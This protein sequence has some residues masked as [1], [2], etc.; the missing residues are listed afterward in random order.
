MSIYDYPYGGHHKIATRRFKRLEHVYY[1]AQ[2]V[3][4]AGLVKA[5]NR[6]FVSLQHVNLVLGR[7]TDTQFD[8]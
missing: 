5:L 8:L 1:Y 6:C 3:G 2:R 4:W 7:L